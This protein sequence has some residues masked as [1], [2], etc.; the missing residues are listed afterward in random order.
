VAGVSR[1][2]DELAAAG[3]DVV[4]GEIETIDLDRRSVTVVSGGAVATHPFDHLV[5]ALGAGYDWDAVPGSRD[6]HTFY[7]HEGAVRLRHRLGDLTGGTVAVVVGPPPV[8]CPPAPIEAILIIDWWARRQGIRD[9]L[10]LHLALPDAAPLGVAGPDASRRVLDQLTRS[11]V[12]VHTSADV[13]HVADGCE[14]HFADGRTLATDVLAVVPTHRVPA[15]VA[16]SG[17]TVGKPWVPVDAATLETAV[18]GVFAV[19]DVNS[20]PLGPGRAVPKAGVFAAGQGV[21]AARVIASRILGEA[22]PPPYEAVGHCFLAFSGEESAMV[23]GTF[24]GPGPAEVGLSEAT[25]EGMAAKV[26]W[27]DDWQAFRI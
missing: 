22:P 14:A 8:K 6:A 19:G 26:R 24:L 2:L 23:G 13:T 10:D 15:V 3:V 9:A 16:R 17:L 21:A 18:A 20:I 1:S 4:I 25:A 12:T 11:G 7:E 27:E 5:V